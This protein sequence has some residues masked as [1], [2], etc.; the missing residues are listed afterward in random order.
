MSLTT[1]SF[2]TPYNLI[3]NK[4]NMAEYLIDSYDTGDMTLESPLG[5]AVAVKA[6][7]QSL[8]PGNDRVLT[9][10]MFFINKTGS[11]SGTVTAKLYA[12]TG[13]FG[14][15]G[16]PT[17][18]AL[19]TSN[20]IN[21]DN[22]AAEAAPYLIEF[23]FE[24][25][26]AY[27]IDS[28]LDYFII[29]D[30]GDLTSGSVRIAEDASVDTHAGN[31]AEYES[32]SWSSGANDVGFYIYGKDTP[33]VATLTTNQVG[34]ISAIFNG[35]LHASHPTTATERGFVYTTQT[36]PNPGDVSPALSDYEDSMSETGT[37]AEESFSIK[38]TDLDPL[39]EYYVR[40]YAKNAAGYSYGA[41]ISVVTGNSTDASFLNT[42]PADIFRISI[43]N[44]VAK[45]GVVNYD[46][47]SVDE[48]GE[49]L[50]YSF[51]SA[52]TLDGIKVA[53][54][55]APAGW[56]WYV[57][58]GTNI[59]YFKNTPTAP[60]HTLTKGKHLS[61]IQIMLSTEDVKN[62]V[63]FTGGNVGNSNL[64]K[65]YDDQ[66]SVNSY[67]PRIDRRTD[68]RVTAA[69]TA[70]AYANGVIQT[71][72]DESETA[73]VDVV[74]GTYDITLFKP[75]DTVSF[76]GFGNFIDNLV[77][78]VSRVNYSPTKVRLTLG[79]LQSRLSSSVEQVRRDLLAIQT[80]S[81]P[82]TPS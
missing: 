81:N 47:S 50:D 79:N 70:A 12:H 49:L 19:A 48:S 66:P 26:D 45:G 68:N 33:E 29:M 1:I 23:I 20:P 37:F 58:L 4:D 41:E 67:G 34:S 78:Q 65:Y 56:Y 72:K 10:A 42:D 80:V 59:A 15:G 27:K 57:D 14:S 51:R 54:N 24:N 35:E 82:D 44:S 39:T 71:R 46:V 28:S 63:Y 76:N 30:G 38:T 17:G 60:T 22:I 21:T 6:V 2:R 32:G 77:L 16:T 11:Q 8:S 62:Q 13:T 3:D 18:A 43:D 7:G 69:T 31:S 64:F 36:R 5:F 61:S 55:L 74:D 75:G 73:Q 25:E 52:T 53:Q 9:R 40:A